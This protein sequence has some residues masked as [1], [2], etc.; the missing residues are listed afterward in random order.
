M[1]SQ[2]EVFETLDYISSLKNLIIKSLNS[3]NFD[4]YAYYHVLLDVF[5][6]ILEEFIAEGSYVPLEK[7]TN[8][9]ENLCP[10]RIFYAK[11]VFY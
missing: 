9:D 4:V 8:Q 7:A 10:L 1:I 6:L 2:K 11:E 5:E 3:E